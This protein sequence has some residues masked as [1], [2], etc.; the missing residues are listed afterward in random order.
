MRTTNI[1]P[2]PIVNVPAY[3]LGRP[4]SIYLDKFATVRRNRPAGTPRG[5]VT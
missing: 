1:R 2:R 3:F 5:A 4:N